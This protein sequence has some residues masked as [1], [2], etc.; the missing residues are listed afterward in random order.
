MGWW[1]ACGS[2]EAIWWGIGVL[3]LWRGGDRYCQKA[4]DEGGGRKVARAM[5][6]VPVATAEKTHGS[7]GGGGGDGREVM[8]R[9][10]W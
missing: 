5:A 6:V 7:E 4:G 9:E 2:G 10:V 1:H 8:M 3:L